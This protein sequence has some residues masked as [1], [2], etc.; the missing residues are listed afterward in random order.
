M[1]KN[2]QKKIYTR[3]GKIKNL[4]EVTFLQDYLLRKNKYEMESKAKE[5]ETQKYAK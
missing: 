2:R 4:A 5:N 3:I 1:Y